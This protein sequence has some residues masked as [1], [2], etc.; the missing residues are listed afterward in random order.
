MLNVT[1]LP[2]SASEQQ[3]ANSTP[4]FSAA[5]SGAASASL[6]AA[7]M[8]TASAPSRI[9]ALKA[10]CTFSGEPSVPTCLTDQPRMSAPSWRIG[11]CTAHA[12]TP[13]LMNVIFLPVGMSL[14]IGL[15]WVIS[16]G[17][18]DASLAACVGGA[19]VGAAAAA[20]SAAVVLAAAGGHRQQQCDESGEHVRAGAASGTG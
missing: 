13:Q 6:S 12:S 9:A 7:L 16:V 14:P 2:C 20:A 17:R 4:A 8:M 19:A 3:V 1:S 15:V 10:P 11:P 5:A 18:V